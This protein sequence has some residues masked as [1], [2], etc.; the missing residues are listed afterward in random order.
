MYSTRQIWKVAYPILI[1]LFMQNLINI[2]DTAYLGRVGEVELGASALAGVFYMA[3]FMIGFGFSTGAQILMARR[4]GEGLYREIGGIMQ[5]STLFLLGLAGVIFGF[6]FFYSP[7]ILGKLITSEA[8]GQAAVKYMNWRIYG[9]FFS[10][11]AI[12]FRAF[13][14]GITQTKVLTINSVVMV[15]SNVVL[16]YMLIFGKCGFPQMGIA[17]AALASVISE[18]ISVVFYTVYLLRKV[19]LQ[20]YGF[21]IPGSFKSG[22][23]KRVLNISVWIMIQNFLTIGTWFLFFVAVEHLGERSLA[24]S[25]IVRSLSTLMFIP[26]SAFATTASTLVSNAVGAGRSGD[27]FPICRKVI[28]ISFLILL[29]VWMLIYLFPQLMLRIYTDNIEL[30]QSAVPSL[31]VL[32]AC[33]VWGAPGA[34]FFN[35]VSGTGNTRSALLI[36]TGMLVFYVA[37]I[38]IAIFEYRVNVMYSWIAEHIYWFTM[39]LFSYVYL[40][41]ARWQNKK[42]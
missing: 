6:T 18:A 22:Q 11:T 35:A 27:L 15:L 34:V 30:L 12:M 17:G 23:L 42:I 36:E 38:W 33:Y 7:L 8:V 21:F 19:D 25:N 28:G 31:F 26:V 3:M 4:N 40:K 29:P 41:K 5:Q 13:F 16:N 2:T 14:V 20:R 1:S 9:M 10:F 24:V 37:Y 39:L 32:A